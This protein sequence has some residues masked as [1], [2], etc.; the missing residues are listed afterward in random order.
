MG[1]WDVGP[2][3]NDTAGD[4]CDALDEVAEGERKG[5]I[6]D[7]LVRTINTHGHLDA[8]VAEETVAAAALVAVQCPSGEPVSPHYGP[9]QPL[10]DL[11]DLRELAAKALDRVMIKPSELMELWGQSDGGPWRDH[12]SRLRNM[13]L[14]PH[15]GDQLCQS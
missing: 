1:T 6:R 7:T 15:P 8:D 10:P 5:I 2:F 4:F 13:L 12:I 9:E 14:P 3:D 11:A